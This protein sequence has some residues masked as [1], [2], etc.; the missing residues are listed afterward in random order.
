MTGATSV[1]AVGATLG[2]GP[3][4]SVSEQ[5]LW[6]V[7][8]KQKKIHRF[9]PVEERLESWDAPAQPGW[10]LPASDGSLIT[11]LQSGLHCFDPASKRFIALAAPEADIPGNRLNDATV[12]P[13]GRLW[14]GS[15]DDG[16]TEATGQVWQYDRGHIAKARIAPV[17]ITNG[18]AFSPN[19]RILYHV[20]TLGRTIHAFDVTNDGMVSGHRVFATIEEGKGYPDGPTVDSEGNVWIA[21]FG[22]WGVRRYSPSGELTGFVRLPVANVT[23]I[24]FGGS[25]FRTAYATTARKGLSDAE[26]ADQPHAGDLFS[27]RVEVPGLPMTAIS[28]D[29]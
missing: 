6:F 8:I 1:C 10:I 20:D 14:F 11:G 28:L 17:T 7:D 26:L 27:F 16:E 5:K 3:C 9:D 23:K 2:E 25:G 29:N 19:G 24:A 12:D 21:L 4:W 22:G 15:M 13:R 18:P